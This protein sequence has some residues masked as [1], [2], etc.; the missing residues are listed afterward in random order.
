MPRPAKTS[1]DARSNG[2]SSGHENAPS[3]AA[4]DA[5]AAAARIPIANSVS[6]RNQASSMM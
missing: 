5:H 3:V 6:A 2:R 4:P 1:S